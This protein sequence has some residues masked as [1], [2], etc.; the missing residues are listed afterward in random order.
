MLRLTEPELS[1]LHHFPARNS[2][3]LLHTSRHPSRHIP[4]HLGQLRLLPHFQRLMQVSF[5]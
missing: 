2:R 1:G 4:F 5:V 3:I